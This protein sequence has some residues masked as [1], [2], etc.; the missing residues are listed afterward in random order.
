MGAPGP[1]SMRCY[2]WQN[3]SIHENSHWLWFHPH[4]KSDLLRGVT[5]FSLLLSGMRGKRRKALDAAWGDL[6]QG[7]HPHLKMHPV[8][9][10]VIRNVVGVF[11]PLTMQVSVTLS[12]CVIWIPFRTAHQQ[13]NLFQSEAGPIHSHSLKHNPRPIGHI[14]TVAA[15]HLLYLVTWDSMLLSPCRMSSLCHLLR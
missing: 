3:S 8:Y 2:C 5:H 4:N 12:T 6:C 1:P 14:N 13:G 11:L 15:C 7:T 10:G 9:S